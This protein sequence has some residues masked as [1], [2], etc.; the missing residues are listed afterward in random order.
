MTIS[1]GMASSGGRGAFLDSD[2]APSVGCH[3][4]IAAISAPVPLSATLSPSTDSAKR[5]LLAAY[6]CP[7]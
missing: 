4:R 5:A 1:S 7:E 3:S 2:S 6:S